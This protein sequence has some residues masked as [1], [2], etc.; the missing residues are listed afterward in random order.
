L[1]SVSDDRLTTVVL[2]VVARELDMHPEELT[3]GTRL[4]E[5]LLLD[6][7]G[8]VELAM[9]LEDDMNVALGDEDLVEVHTLGDLV[10]LVASS[11]S[12]GPPA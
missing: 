9:A 12:F 7:V 3:L 11:P 10:E 6:S 2:S 4:I 1:L 5:D 8:T